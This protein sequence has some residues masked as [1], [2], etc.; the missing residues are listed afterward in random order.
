MLISVLFKKI[1]IRK[2]IKIIKIVFW[3]YVK[4]VLKKYF[5]TDI[6]DSSTP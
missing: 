5:C 2:K 1:Y 6:K 4:N 3:N